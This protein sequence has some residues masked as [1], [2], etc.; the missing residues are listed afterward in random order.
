MVGIL[1][2]DEPPLAGDRHAHR[3]GA[4]RRQHRRRRRVRAATRWPRSSSPRCSRRP[5]FP[6]GWSTSSP[7][8]QAELAPWLASHMDVNAIDVTGANGDLAELERS[9]AENVKRVV[10]GAARRTEPLGHRGVRRAEDRLAPDRP[11]IGAG[12]LRFSRAHAAPVERGDLRGGGD[13]DARSRHR[14]PPRLPPRSP[15]G[16]EGVATVGVVDDVRAATSLPILVAGA[17][18]AGGERVG[19]GRLAAGRRDG[20]DELEP[21]HALARELG[22]ECV[23]DVADEEELE[24]VLERIDPEIVLLSP[25]EAEEEDAIDRVLELL[26]D[27]PAGKLV[28]AELPAAIGRGADRARARRSGRDPRARR[29]GPRRRLTRWRRALRRYPFRPCAT[30][31]SSRSSPS[32]RPAAAARA[33]NPR[34]PRVRRRRP[35]PARRRGRP[36]GSASRTTSAAPSTAPRG[37][38]PRSTRRSTAGSR[39]AAGSTRTSRTS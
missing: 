26:P 37:C 23:V 4:G 11:L 20:G 32:S 36:A 24:A 2:P 12:C 15:P 22:L 5:T 27:V 34:A 30:S 18:P 29:Q 10:R 9:A 21:R 1:C 33:V 14:R 31:S 35:R 38:R 8:W 3:A 19:C 17:S 7:G 25:R 39:T 6:A 28:L 13:L 16:A